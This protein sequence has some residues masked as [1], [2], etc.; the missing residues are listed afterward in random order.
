MLKLVLLDRDGVINHQSSNYIQAPS[1]WRPIKGSPEAIARLN[2]HDL[3]VAV[4]SNQSAVGRG[5][6]TVEML[7]A[8]NEKMTI[9]LAAVGARL[10]R[11]YTC[12][13]HPNADCSCRK[14]KPGMLRKAMAAFNV[15]PAE[16][17]FIGDS[18][19]D[20]EAASAANCAPFL[21]LTGHGRRDEIAAR[22][23][24]LNQVHENLATAVSSIVI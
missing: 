24:G 9:T 14:P 21:V 3:I 17:C 23:L 18:L 10:E 6:I 20:I 2:G 11:I 1:D 8:I 4:C 22:D 7:G 5:I 15:T 16:T 12:P 13:H 19:S